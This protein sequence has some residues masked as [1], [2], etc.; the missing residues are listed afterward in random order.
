VRIGIGNFQALA[1]QP[2]YL[3]RTSVP[4]AFAYLSHKILRWIAPH[5]LLL[6]LFASLLLAIDSTPWRVA[7]AAQIVVYLGAAALYWR[8]LGGR[9][10]GG[11]KR[12]TGQRQVEESLHPGIVRP[13][14]PVALSIPCSVRSHLRTH[15]ARARRRTTGAG[16][17]PAGRRARTP[18]RR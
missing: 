13:L 16:S 8:S 6:A 9:R 3:F 2:E 11:L 7:A 15:S 1:R 4:T 18:C 12:Q 14:R 17:R 5:L 10:L